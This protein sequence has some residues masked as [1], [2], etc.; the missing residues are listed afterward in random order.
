VPCSLY[1]D[2]LPACADGSA[3]PCMQVD[4]SKRCAHMCEW[5][6]GMQVGCLCGPETQKEACCAPQHWWHYLLYCCEQELRCLLG[7]T[8]CNMAQ[9]RTAQLHTTAFLGCQGRPPSG[10]AQAQLTF[11]CL[12]CAYA[13][14]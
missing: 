14:C 4:G 11:Q 5:L 8:A 7:I 12:H 6:Q 2:T 10:I 9:R 3:E 13:C 1:A